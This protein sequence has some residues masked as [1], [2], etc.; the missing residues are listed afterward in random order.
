MYQHLYHALFLR[1]ANT[2]L[3]MTNIT[4]VNSVSCWQKKIAMYQIRTPRLEAILSTSADD[5]AIEEYHLLHNVIAVLCTHFVAIK[6]QSDSTSS[7]I[8][9]LMEMAD[10]GSPPPAGRPDLLL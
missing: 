2:N 5:R 1:I 3:V 8:A 4:I 9:V 10:Q 6:S 7:N